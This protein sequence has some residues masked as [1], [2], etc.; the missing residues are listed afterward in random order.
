M[1]VCGALTSKRTNHQH[2]QDLYD[3]TTVPQPAGPVRYSAVIPFRIQ[4]GAPHVLRCSGLS[5]A[6][7]PY[8]LGGY[9]ADESWRC[10]LALVVYLTVHDIH[11]MQRTDVDC[12]DVR[13]FVAA[14][15]SSKTCQL[16]LRWP[17]VRFCIARATR[18]SCL[19]I[20]LRATLSAPLQFSRH[21]P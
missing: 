19:V 9:K 3:C 8:Y 4:A 12:A 16:A 6:E 1:Q 20:G 14:Q 21:R 17:T 10:A 2:K 11:G 15:L 13:Q 7:G 18:F 5:N